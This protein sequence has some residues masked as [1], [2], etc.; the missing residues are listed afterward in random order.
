M[1]AAKRRE[2]RLQGE[3]TVGKTVLTGAK[4]RLTN[5]I[6]AAVVRGTDALSLRASCW[7]AWR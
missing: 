4:D 6:S 5:R 1:H 2:L 3:G 7:I